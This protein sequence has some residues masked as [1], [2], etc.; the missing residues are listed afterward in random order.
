MLA[1]LITVTLRSVRIKS[2]E[3]I[4]IYNRN[5]IFKLNGYPLN[6]DIH[7]TPSLYCSLIVFRIQ[8]GTIGLDVKK[9]VQL[10]ILILLPK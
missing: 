5:E 2:F 4:P 3:V 1:P 10:L 6:S 9:D 8:I 7:R